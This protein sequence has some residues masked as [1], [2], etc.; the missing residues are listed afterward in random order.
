MVPALCETL[1]VQLLDVAWITQPERGW[2][3]PTARVNSFEEEGRTVRQCGKDNKALAGQGI[4]HEVC[5]PASQGMH[6][7]TNYIAAETPKQ[8]KYSTHPQWSLYEE[9]FDSIV[10][11]CHF[12]ILA[13]LSFTTLAS[14]YFPLLQEKINL[15]QCV[16]LDSTGLHYWTNTYI[17]G[18]YGRSS[19]VSFALAKGWR[20]LTVM[21]RNNH[22]NSYTCYI[23]LLLATS[24]VTLRTC[25]TTIV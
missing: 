15:L 17:Q 23:G 2:L 18:S 1:L 9:E 16:L 5:T 19:K 10:Y 24:A 13:S 8:R 11:N 7:G 3:N 14:F 12:R 25:I 20:G 22:S 6:L 21:V 4:A